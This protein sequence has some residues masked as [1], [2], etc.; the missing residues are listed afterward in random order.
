MKPEQ[1]EKKKS[2]DLEDCSGQSFSHA[3]PLA[4]PPRPNLPLAWQ[5]TMIVLTCMCTFGNHWSNG[6]IAALKTTIEKNLD[7][8]NSKFAALVSVTNLINTFL[9]IGFGFVIDRFGGPLLTVILAFCHLA[10]ALIEAGSATNHLNSYNVLIA[11][12]VIAAIGDGSLDNAQH[13]IFATYFAPGKGLAFSIDS[14]P[15]MHYIY[16]LL[17]PHEGM[18][19]S[20]A[21]LAQFVGQSTANVIS[22]K[23]GS[24]AWPLWI[25]S[26]ISL[27]SFLCAIAVF[28]LDRYLQSQY[29]VI[30][31]TARNRKQNTDA[32]TVKSTAI[33]IAAVRHLP[34]TFWIVVLFSVFE[35]SGMQS[36]LSIS[37]S[38]VRTTKAK[39]GGCG[40][41][42]GIELLPS[43][44][45]GHNSFLGYLYRQ[46]WAP[47]IDLVPAFVCA[48]VLYAISQSITPAP[49]VE[50]IRNIIPDPRFYA[51]AFAI[52]KSVV[53][54]SVVIIVTAAG[55]IQDLSPTASLASSVTLW[56]VYAFVSVL[57]SGA[58]LLACYTTYGKQILPAARL[59]Q[60][61]PR[62]L[63]S[64]IE[65]LWRCNR[66]TSSISDTLKENVEIVETS[67]ED[68]ILRLQLLEHSLKSPIDSSLSLYTRWGSV[69]AS[70]V[71]IVI[72]WVIFGLG[73]EW[74]VHGCCKTSRRLMTQLIFGR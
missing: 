18:I 57:V 10:G 56:L 7:I 50:I 15:P 20:M 69:I 36:F 14:D 17:L 21:N 73:I 27:F 12:K 22:K 4:G 31:Q 51:T 65:L 35:N 58:L 72:A 67:P 41:W 24:F 63:G 64:E 8:N 45:G 23:L 2:L 61:R 53:Q 71:V 68:R 39:K 26:A 6:L 52:K 54:A 34:L 1:S 49:Q 46:V 44:A 55:K 3:H 47:N 9:C 62:R 37:T 16:Y 74:G 28:L 13:R 70:L 30:D 25:S 33:R 42:L 40:W 38:A 5:V 66:S 48:Y 19:W 43:L 59:S 29:N 32:R 11:G 60:I